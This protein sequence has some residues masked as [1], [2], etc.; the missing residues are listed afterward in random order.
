MPQLARAGYVTEHYAH[1]Q[2]LRLVPLSAPFV[3]SAMWRA[4]YV[5]AYAPPGTRAPQMWFLSLMA[6]AVAASYLIGA[7]YRRSFGA[8]RPLPGHSG[9]AALI[10]CCATVLVLLWA[11]E[12][13]RWSVPMPAAFLFLAFM[14]LGLVE[15]GL[16]KHYLAI[17]AMVFALALLGPA[18]LGPSARAVCL[19]GFIAVALIVAGVGDDL[20]LRRTLHPAGSDR[21]EPAL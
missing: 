3:A 16:R 6:V 11:Q 21:Y 17:G 20:V 2:G 9:A 10:G 4:G 13:F 12:S 18:E 1:L 7:R 14:R 8:V 15:G 5:D 19:D